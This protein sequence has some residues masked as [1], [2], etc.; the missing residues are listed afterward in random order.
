[1][2][3]TECLNGK[4]I[5]ITI[6]SG[7]DPFEAKDICNIFTKSRDREQHMKIQILDHTEVEVAIEK[8]ILKEKEDM[9][10]DYVIYKV[11]FEGIVV[12]KEEK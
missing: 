7:T 1:M 11:E 4:N 5:K 6:Y 9:D 3:N 2:V 12:S 8:V 10:R